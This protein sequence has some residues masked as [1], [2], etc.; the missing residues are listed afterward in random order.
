M[1]KMERFNNKSSSVGITLVIISLVTLSFSTFYLM[2]ENRNFKHQL[3]S[4]EYYLSELR[5]KLQVQSVPQPRYIQRTQRIQ[6]IPPQY[7]ENYNND[8]NR[9]LMSQAY[10]ECM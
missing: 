9:K 2:V 3:Q 8:Y 1:E 7:R 6:R 10:V 5:D 4:L